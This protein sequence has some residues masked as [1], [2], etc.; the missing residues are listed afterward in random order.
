VLCNRLLDGKGHA[1]ALDTVGNVNEWPLASLNTV[2]E[3]AGLVEEEIV[4]IEIFNAEDLRFG[5][6]KDVEGDGEAGKVHDGAAIVADDLALTRGRGLQIVLVEM[7]G[8]NTRPERGFHED[9]GGVFDVDLEV[10]PVTAEGVD[11]EREAKERVEVVEL[12]D[13]CYDDTAAEVGAGGI[14]SAI[15]LVRM[16][17]W[18][19]L[20]YGGTDRQQSA[21]DARADDLGESKDAGMETELV[22]NHTDA[23]V[24]AGEFDELCGA[25]EGVGDGFFEEN[26][27]SGEEASAGD[28]DMKAAGVADVGD[29]GLLGKS[30]F[31]RAKGG[32]VVDLF[33]VIRLVSH[34][35]WSYNVGEAADAISND[36][37]CIAQQSA[38][39]AGVALTDAA[40]AYDEN[41][42]EKTPSA[43][44]G[45]ILRPVAANEG[46]LLLNPADLAA[47][48]AASCF[49]RKWAGVAYALDGGKGVVEV[50]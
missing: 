41:F 34:H 15:V 23:F 43:I 2:E 30:I 7:N 24:D 11:A 6:A 10:A 40:E 48:L 39:V 28:G 35:D 32:D 21:E 27:A 3:V 29:V 49:E 18:E 8:E 50:G 20:P 45:A 33:N 47:R 1:E 25:V 44:V 26:V 5:L 9:G 17:V 13:L 37:D 16:P 42:H 14:A 19:V 38:K 4:A 36:F 31:E 12:V 22:A 46:E